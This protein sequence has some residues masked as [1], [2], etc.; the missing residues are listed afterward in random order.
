MNTT[1]ER[2]N[3]I[4]AEETNSVLRSARCKARASE[5]GYGFM[6][7]GNPIRY[8]VIV[9]IEAKRLPKSLIEARKKV[10]RM[11]RGEH[12]EAYKAAYR[13]VEARVTAYRKTHMD[14]ARK[15]LKKMGIRYKTVVNF[16]VETLLIRDF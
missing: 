3:Q 10:Q 13:K 11:P 15:A 14:K 1:A 7:P 9:E 5:V 2:T 8:R 6:S 4:L 12:K 16:G